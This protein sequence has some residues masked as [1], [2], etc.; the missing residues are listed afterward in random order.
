[1]STTRTGI[2]WTDRSAVETGEAQDDSFD[3]RVAER[4]PLFRH[5]H[6]EIPVALG[7]VAGGACWRDVARRRS[8]S[9]RDRHDVVPR[10]S[11]PLAAVSAEP[12]ELL[13]DVDLRVCGNRVDAPLA[14][15]RLLASRKSD[16]FA[17][18]VVSA[19]ILT[20]VREALSGVDLGRREKC[21][22]GA[23]PLQTKSSLCTSLVAPRTDDSRTC[24][25][26][27][28]RRRMAVHTRWICMEP[29]TRTPV[30]A[31]GAP[32]LANLDAGDVL[33]KCHAE[34]LRGRADDAKPRAHPLAVAPLG[35][36]RESRRRA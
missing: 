18:G 34:P 29:R 36:V 3:K 2:A 6:I 25:A 33:L 1:M 26:R 22:A 23:A 9:V 10:R 11:W 31:F 13:E 24:S 8:T 14:R 19:R 20:T 16:V 12:V 35:G 4:E 7:A 5:P 21:R 28:T 30:L 27:R 17:L 15:V 32:L